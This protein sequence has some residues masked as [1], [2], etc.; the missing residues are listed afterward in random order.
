MWGGA[1]RGGGNEENPPK[2]AREDQPYGPTKAG[3]P[4]AC[5]IP[6]YAEKR[7]NTKQKKKEKNKTVLPKR[8]KMV[9]FACHF[10]A[11]WRGRGAGDRNAEK[12]KFHDKR[13]L[14][15]ISKSRD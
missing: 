2:Y 5:N 15:G 13:R 12:E 7:A 6:Y 11:I 4:G 9:C 10:L 3:R 8:G 14:E 1:C